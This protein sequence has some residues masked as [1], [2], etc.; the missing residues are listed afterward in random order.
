MFA[1]LEITK[2]I[3]FKYSYHRTICMGGNEYNMQLNLVII[4][5]TNVSKC[6]QLFLSVEKRKKEGRKGIAALC[7]QFI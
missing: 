7:P 6:I 3:D 5:Y 4:Q 2:T 1:F